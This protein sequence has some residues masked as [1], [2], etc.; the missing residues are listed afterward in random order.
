[1]VKD[2]PEGITKNLFLLVFTDMWMNQVMYKY[3]KNYIE[4]ITVLIKGNSK[5][6]RA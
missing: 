1:M 2:Y 5:I 6:A 4:K 3:Q